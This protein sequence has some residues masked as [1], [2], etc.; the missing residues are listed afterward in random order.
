MS[1]IRLALAV[2][3]IVAIHIRQTE[4]GACPEP[5]SHPTPIRSADGTYRYPNPIIYY[6]SVQRLSI[7][8]W[9]ELW[10]DLP[11]HGGRFI[12]EMTERTCRR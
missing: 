12:E 4:L 9:H 11:E 10:T 5:P 1:L 8:E 3:L 6:D 2:A 7:W